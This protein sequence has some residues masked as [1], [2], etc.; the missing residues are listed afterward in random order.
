MTESTGEASV[1]P[2]LWFIRPSTISVNFALLTG[3]AQRLNRVF[4][5][6]NP[7]F[8]SMPSLQAA[9]LDSFAVLRKHGNKQDGMQLYSTHNPIWHIY[10]RTKQ[11]V[12]AWRHLRTC[13]SLHCSQSLT[14]KFCRSFAVGCASPS[15]SMFTDV[16]SKLSPLFWL[17]RTNGTQ[18]NLLT[19]WPDES[20]SE[21]L[22]WSMIVEVCFF[23]SCAQGHISGFFKRQILFYI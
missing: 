11:S 13:E 6:P 20:L 22:K 9:A 21:N 8:V 7:I 18:P 4:N 1:A 19:L 3:H 14:F 5:F 23:F 2:S 16:W 17:F 10:S 15:R 12:Q